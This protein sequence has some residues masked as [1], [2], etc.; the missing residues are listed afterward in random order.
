[1]ATNLAEG[2]RNRRSCQHG[3]DQCRERRRSRGVL[4]A[5]AFVCAL[6]LNTA[7]LSKGPA[8]ESSAKASS[9][10]TQGFRNTQAQPR[11]KASNI[12]LLDSNALV[13]DLSIWWIDDRRVFFQGYDQ[14]KKSQ[15][16]GP[17]TRDL[18]AFYVWDTQS[19]KLARLEKPMSNLVCVNGGLVAYFAPDTGAP[20]S[21]WVLYIGKWGQEKKTSVTRSDINAK[22]VRLNPVSCRVHETDPE[23]AQFDKVDE[24]VRF[25]WAVKPLREEHGFLRVAR[26]G[27]I[28]GERKGTYELALYSPT[29]RNPIS[30]LQ[31]SDDRARGLGLRVAYVP[32]LRNYLLQGTPSTLNRDITPAWLLS[33][34]G[35]LRSIAPATSPTPGIDDYF[36]VK[37]GVL[38]PYTSVTDHIDTSMIGAWL[39]RKSGID[40]LVAGVVQN[41][42]VAPSGCRVAFSHAIH[43]KAHYDGLASLRQGG[44]GYTTLKMLDLCRP[45]GKK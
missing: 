15:S 14:N 33:P 26:G 23:W 11:G 19:N 25:M 43:W 8:A 30:L 13:S 22:R 2:V 45:G 27:E 12:S 36:P 5:T 16:G 20:T 32:F 41:L 42:A 28:S 38:F 35:E 44:R 39:I 17:W 7:A 1:M 31:H 6:S 34:T 9:L 24:D 37:D 4:L 3:L 18:Y 21:D 40:R 29:R 10:V